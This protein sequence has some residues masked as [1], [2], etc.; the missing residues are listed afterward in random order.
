M[1]SVLPTTREGNVFTG[2]CSQGG[3][4]HGQRHPLDRGLLDSVQTEH[5]TRQEVTSY[6]SEETWD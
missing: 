6:T 2:V 1:H 3:L 5:G 4:P